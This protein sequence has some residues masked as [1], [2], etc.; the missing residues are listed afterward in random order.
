MD[1]FEAA[2]TGN[3]KALEKHIKGGVDVDEVDR[4]GN[5]ALHYASE[6]SLSCVKLLIEARADINPIGRK[7]NTPLHIAAS[8]GDAAITPLLI[9]AGANIH[10][11]NDYGWQPLQTAAHRGDAEIVQVLLTA[12]AAA[13]EDKI[14][15][16]MN[17]ASQK[18]HSACLEILRDH[19]ERPVLEKAAGKTALPSF[20]KKQL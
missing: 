19:L 9:E 20:V 2:E 1:I 3:T 14:K 7:G 16:A 10:A 12:E 5:T 15:S 8:L 18:G 11:E 17:T 6:F 4:N 13:Y